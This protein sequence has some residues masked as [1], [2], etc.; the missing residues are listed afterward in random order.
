MNPKYRVAILDDDD[1]V[2]QS[3]SS[4][5]RSLGHDV[6]TFASAA[7]FLA[8]TDCRPHCLITDIQMPGMS[9]DALQ[10]I[11]LSRGDN[12]PMIF[13]TAFPTDALRA[14]V[15]GRGGHAFLVKPVDGEAMSRCLA[16]ALASV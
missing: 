7:A 6:C 9:G 14:R 16:Q 11:L 5:V 4:L 10:E 1:G 15:M 13:M 3:L 12:L 2:R 8:D